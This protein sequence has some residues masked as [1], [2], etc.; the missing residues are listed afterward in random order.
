[1][2]KKFSDASGMQD[3]F[4]QQEIDQ[5]TAQF[6]VAREKLENEIREL[7]NNSYKFDS[8]LSDVETRNEIRYLN[9]EIKYLEQ[10]YYEDIAKIKSNQK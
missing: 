7:E 5:K 6:E 3:M 8:G 2:A 9:E 10:K 1:M 4:I